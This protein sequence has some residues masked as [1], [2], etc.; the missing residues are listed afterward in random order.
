MYIMA[1]IDYAVNL[2]NPSIGAYNSIP[3]LIH[4]SVS[5]LG[6]LSLLIWGT[7]DDLINYVPLLQKPLKVIQEK[8]K[9]TLSLVPSSSVISGGTKSSNGGARTRQFNIIESRHIAPPFP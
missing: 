1:I 7:T 5:F 3:Y 6:S 8:M 9:A 2:Y 4:F